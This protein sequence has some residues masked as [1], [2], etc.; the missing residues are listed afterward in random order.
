MRSPED[1]IA[2]A[3]SYDHLP[4]SGARRIIEALRE[5]GY[6]IV[7]RGGTVTRLPETTAMYASV[8]DARRLR[9]HMDALRPVNCDDAA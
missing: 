1:V 8:E 2:R 4:G 6:E 9:R 3:I 7:P 5:E